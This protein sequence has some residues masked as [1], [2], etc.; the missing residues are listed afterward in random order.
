M[1]AQN[2]LDPHVLGISPQAQTAL[3]KV[4][5]ML[6]RGELHHCRRGDD[7][8]GNGFNLANHCVELS[9]GTVACI[10]GWADIVA[11]PHRLDLLRQA[12]KR[13]ALAELFAPEGLSWHAITPEQAALALRNYLTLGE[14]RWEEALTGICAAP[15]LHAPSEDDRV[16]A[17]SPTSWPGIASR[18][19][20][21]AESESRRPAADRGCAR[22]ADLVDCER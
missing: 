13:A 4:L 7:I 9:C 14:P 11:R 19:R 15:S 5:G 6:E 16:A 2:F 12:A 17:R 20:G 8:S 18:L 10:A 21:R 1:L 22:L 3:I